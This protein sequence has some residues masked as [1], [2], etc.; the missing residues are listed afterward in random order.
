MA[1]G[2]VLSL[3]E[4][5]VL[6]ALSG[7]ITVDRTADGPTYAGSIPPGGTP[8]LRFEQL[9]VGSGGVSG[10]FVIDGIDAN[11]PLLATFQG[12]D[13]G[14]TR[15][16]LTFLD[17][18]FA[19]SDI[20]GWFA[21]PFFLNA[22]GKPEKLDVEVVLRQHLGGFSLILAAQQ[23]DPKKQTP[24]GLVHLQYPLKEGSGLVDLTLASFE[25]VQYNGVWQVVL[26][27][28]L[29]LTTVGLAW[30]VFEFK[31]LRIDST[32]K[33]EI[34]GG[35][36]D[37]P[38]HTSL[39]YFG[40]HVGLRRF[41][42][43][44]DGSGQ[45][46]IGIDGDI[47]LVEGLPLGGSVRGL[48]INLDT[49]HVSFAGVAVS[50]EISGVLSISGE[51]DHVQVQAKSGTDPQLA[52]AGLPP[53][54]YGAS[55][56][57]PGSVKTIDV[58]TGKVD[59]V[60]I[61]AGGLE[62]AAQFIAGKFNGVS[63]FFL[64]LDLELPTGIPIF[65]DV[66]LF[67]LEG[68]VATN[69][70]P[71]PESVNHTWWEWYKYDSLDHTNSGDPTDYTVEE[72]TKWL[73][74]EPGGF[75]LGAG[76]TIGTSADDGY[77]ASAWIAFVLILP[78]PVLMLVGKANI[79]SKRISGASDDPSSV[80]LT[81]DAL[82][83]YDGQADVFDMNID[84]QYRIPVVLDIEA[85]AA[86]HVDRKQD[87]WYLAL[88]LPP[89]DKRVRARIFDL[90]EADCY[91]VVG[92]QGVLAGSYIGYRGNYSVGPF[93][94][95]LDVYM[96]TI[97]AIEWSPLTLGGG[98]ELHGDAYVSAFGLS[99]SISAD[100]TL[101]GRAPDPL[102]IHGELDISI[103]TPWPLPDIDFS[104][105]LEWGSDGIP[106]RAALALA[107]VDATSVDHAGATDRYVLL[108]HRSGW[109]RPTPPKPVLYDSD[110]S[111][112]GVLNVTP[113]KFWPPPGVN[114]SDPLAVLRQPPFL[115][116]PGP[117]VVTAVPFAALVPQDAHFTLNFTRSVYDLAGFPNSD[118]SLPPEPPD[119][120]EPSKL[121]PADDMSHLDLNP[122]PKRR[123]VFRHSLRQVALYQ[124]DGGA[125]TPLASTPK[126]DSVPA[127][128]GGWL[129]RS[130]PATP[131]AAPA[132]SDN[133]ALK[134]VPTLGSG[135][136]P[137]AGQ[138]VLPTSPGFYA[139]KTVTKIE[140]RPIDGDQFATVQD[141]D[142][143]PVIEFAYFQVAGGPGT[144]SRDSPVAVPDPNVPIPFPGL[145]Q[146]YPAPESARLG[147]VYPRGGRL[148][149]LSS[150]SQWSWP[151]DGDPAAYFGYDLNV[152]FNES[153]VH[154]LYRSCGRGDV[155][156]SLHFRCVD[157]NNRHVLYDNLA[158]HVPTFP[159]NAA[160][161]AEPLILPVPAA[162]LGPGSDAAKARELWPGSLAPRT[163]Y[164]LD[165]IAAP[166]PCDGLCLLSDTAAEL[167]ADLQELFA[168]EDQR[169]SLL[170]IQFS[171][172]RYYT[173]TAQLGGAQTQPRKYLLATD[174]AT[175]LAAAWTKAD[176]SAQSPASLLAN[177]Q[178][179]RSKLQQLAAT[180]N[181]LGSALPQYSAAAGPPGLAASRDA[182]DA[183]WGAFSDRSGAVFDDFARAIGRP[184]LAS[185][186]HAPPPPDTELSL[187]VDAAGEVRAVLL[188]SPEPF[189]WRRMVLG[190]DPVG[191]APG[192]R[193]PVML[194]WSVDGTRALLTTANTASLSGYLLDIAF[195]GDIGPEAPAITQCAQ[196]V[197]EQ[198]IVPLAPP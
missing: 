53:I 22:D 101:E 24:D 156:D 196:G 120:A 192:G 106:P 198:A 130:V 12:F 129:P 55:P 143:D 162:L 83:V 20:A 1:T 43:S 40:F 167:V 62:I 109:P 95:G 164:T 91:L 178:A 72:A 5:A 160:L 86:L 110:S 16:D 94:V 176:A 71:D 122:K 168:D 13:V 103:S 137:E 191:G 115:A 151:G 90:F 118:P 163:R 32:G 186:Q 77:A 15:F 141:G 66:S 187:L 88:G 65:L 134:V 25:L 159:A 45:R 79:L 154:R 171:T 19:G 117:N 44:T 153:Y 173:F 46:I 50:F 61:A 57:G 182:V 26:A 38:A 172:S 4:T 8:A 111:K 107:H 42:L 183:A 28:R 174:A 76:A 125:W 142:G 67:G 89:R 3:I 93:G 165:V 51:V 92:S 166:P 127:L 114:A 69:L 180:Y 157:R 41:G 132:A 98:I 9:R 158:T 27:G 6:K 87:E 145:L 34:D 179:A 81:F 195:H 144:V 11:H 185:D 188:E 30:P 58:F 175:W 21:L 80:G 152:E 63:V 121:L 17:G 149:D 189:P 33:V 138:A 100:A 56:G 194:V 84:A 104:L 23:S 64:D 7:V 10:H 75:A 60:I 126:Y 124:Y 49:G 52:A 190:F 148:L 68:L 155:G 119:H 70:R 146:N 161:V 96:A 37:L 97:A 18:G 36:I 35:W 48:E 99:Y 135:E 14:L 85:D 73:A 184:D 59:C 31:G 150:Y 169:T 39:D 197:T 74:P 140:A 123:W 108:S 181:P 147:S 193:L 113:E 112:P 136:G 78:G 128:Q 139:L 29:A 170:R 54:V 47:N 102:W 133:T 82:A 116:P 105:S 131:G 177:Y 2:S